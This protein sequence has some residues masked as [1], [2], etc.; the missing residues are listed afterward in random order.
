LAELAVGLTSRVDLCRARG[1]ADDGKLVALKRLHADLARDPEL[2]AMFRDEIWMAANIDHANVAR[3]VAWGEDHEGAF[4]A[5][6]F[7]RGVSLARLMRTVFSTGERFSDRLAVYLGTC[8]CDGLVAAHELCAPTGEPLGMVHR[9]LTPGN[10][11]VGFDGEV[12]LADFGLAKATQ[13]MVQTAPGLIRGQP[14]YMAPEQVRSEAVDARA[15]IF[16]LGVVLFELVAQRRPW[17]PR[18]DYEAVLALLDSEPADLGALCPRADPGLV[19]LVHRCLA[20]DPAE[21]PESA[22]QLKQELQQWLEAYAY[23]DNVTVLSRF[24]RRNALRQLRWLERTLGEARV[25]TA[26]PEGAA[27]D[28]GPTIR[29]ALTPMDAVEPAPA[30]EA[31]PFDDAGGDDPLEPYAYEAETRRPDGLWQE[32]SSERYTRPRAQSRDDPPGVVA[33]PDSEVPPPPRAQPLEA[34]VSSAQQ[35]F[36][37]STLRLGDKVNPGDF[38]RLAETFGVEAVRLAALAQDAADAARRAAEKVTAAVREAAAS[39]TGA[40]S[41]AERAEIGVALLRAANEALVAA[42]AGRNEEAARKLRELE[43]HHARLRRGR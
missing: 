22:R 38:K 5:V 43:E 3:V 13:R 9:N 34:G 19:R 1:G 30:T 6:E 41:A 37:P 39:V 17:Q 25:P 16:A 20:K 27:Q 31:L 8:V 21:R 2:A 33:A 14:E 26:A 40:R 18:S 36:E 11:L 15:D 23:R 10:I 42:A 4:L 12:K 7:V 24:V 28:D 29:R 35:T 32:L